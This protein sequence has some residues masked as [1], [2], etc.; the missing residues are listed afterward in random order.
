[1]KCLNVGIGKYLSYKYWG[2]SAVTNKKASES[3]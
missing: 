3:K 2:I 1:M